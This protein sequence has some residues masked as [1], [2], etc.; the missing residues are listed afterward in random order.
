MDLLGLD[1]DFKPVDYIRYTNLQWNRRYYECGKWS[2]QIP[3][4][5]YDPRIKYVYTP[6]R[7]EMGLV[8]RMESDTSADGDYVQLSGMFMETIFDRHIAFPHLTGEFKM[9]EL[10]GKICTHEWYKPD[11]YTIVPASNIPDDTVDV[12][13]ERETLGVLMYEMLKEKEKSPRLVFDPDKHTFTLLVWQGLDRTQSQNK[14]SYVP[15]TEASAYVKKFKYVEDDSGY[16][17][18]V[19]VLY[20]EQPSRSDVYGDN[21]IEEGRR[22]LLMSGGSEEEK[23][24]LKQKAKEELL[25]Y[26]IIQRATV[27]VLQTG[28]FYLTDYD[29]G[30]KCDVVSHKFQ[31]SFEARIES[32]DE[33]WKSGRHYVTLHIGEGTKTAY[34]KLR[35]HIRAERF[36]LGLTANL[37]NG[38][39]WT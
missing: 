12:K 15:F 6:D 2:A 30:D 25:S 8:Q 21:A 13:W 39:S 35:R 38:G 16:K 33:V 9:N 26:P 34:Q 36:S 18:V 37:N 22:W 10:L 31:K 19:M 4:D 29:L 3:E 20:G 14:N 27:E 1:K 11:L 23:P 5:T 32:I 17:N 7:P 24:E 28:L